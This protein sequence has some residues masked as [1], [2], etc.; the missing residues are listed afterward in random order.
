MYI[1]KL[2]ECWPTSLNE[3]RGMVRTW[4]GFVDV[5]DGWV[6]GYTEICN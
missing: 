5:L 2:L 6:W 1:I 4:R 3:R